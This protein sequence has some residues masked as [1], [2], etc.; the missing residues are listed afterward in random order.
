ME[1]RKA[2]TAAPAPATSGQR[3]LPNPGPPGDSNAIPAPRQAP[4]TTIDTR[5]RMKESSAAGK[6]AVGRPKPLAAG[7][8]PPRPP[9]IV[10]TPPP[11]KKSVVRSGAYISGKGTAGYQANV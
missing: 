7:R 2:R 10:L 1:K 8:Y 4:A 9:G 11:L 6:K 3:N 5:G